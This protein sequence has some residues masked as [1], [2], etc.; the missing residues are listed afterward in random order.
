[1]NNVVKSPC[2]DI[3]FNANIFDLKCFVKVFIYNRVFV[4]HM[5]GASFWMIIFCLLFLLLFLFSHFSIY[6][7][8]IIRLRNVKNVLNF[9]IRCVESFE[10]FQKFFLS[11]SH[12]YLCKIKIK[13]ID[14]VLLLWTFFASSST[15]CGK[16]EFI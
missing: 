13:I 6:L 16:S 14:L 7:K 5:Q 4:F 15:V 2:S 3:I 1:M 10:I 11:I 12:F 9:W 8:E